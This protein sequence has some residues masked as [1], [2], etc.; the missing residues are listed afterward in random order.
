MM[1]LHALRLFYTVAQT[2][3]V[4]RASQALNISQPA[5]SAQIRKFEKEQD[6][7]LF[8]IQGRQLVL[9]ELGQQLIKR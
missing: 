5:I 6:I 9:T 4:T 2:G 8:E 3:S 1:N 7:V